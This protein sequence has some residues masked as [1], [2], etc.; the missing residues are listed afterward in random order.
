MP[1]ARSGPFGLGLILCHPRLLCRRSRLAFAFGASFA[2]AGVPLEEID[3]L[4]G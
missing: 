3:D 2:K 1:L 4:A